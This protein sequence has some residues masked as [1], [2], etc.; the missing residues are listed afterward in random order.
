VEHPGHLQLVD[1]VGIDLVQV[2]EP[3]VGKVL[4]VI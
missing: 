4:A 1:V 2:L 3:R